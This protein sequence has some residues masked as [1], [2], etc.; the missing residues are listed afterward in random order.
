MLAADA[1]PQI[2]E[3][4]QKM[5]EI[6]C[7]GMYAFAGI[8]LSNLPPSPPKNVHSIPPHSNS[9]RAYYD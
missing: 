9:V 3:Y 2:W 5:P 4:E 8:A 7:S 6:N 1:V